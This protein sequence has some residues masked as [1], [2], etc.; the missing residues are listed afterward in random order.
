M[1]TTVTTTQ[2]DYTTITTTPSTTS[3][4]TTTTTT[5]DTVQ[6]APTTYYAQCASANF[7]ST[8]PNGP[9]Y[10]LDDS[11]SSIIST[12]D[13]SYDCCVACVQN[14]NCD[15]GAFILGTDS[16]NC[17]LF[18]QATCTSVSEYQWQI[19]EMNSGSPLF[20]Y[21]NGNCGQVSSYES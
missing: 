1:S 5:T 20:E 14:A 6:A 9:L 17:A 8:G 13:N 4:A 12:T 16:D 11:S 19:N 18:T 15:W 21:F 7:A 10:G 3:T 2:T